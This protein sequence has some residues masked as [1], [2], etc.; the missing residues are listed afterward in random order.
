MVPAA[1]LKIGIPGGEV[2]KTALPLCR[3]TGSRIRN[4]ASCR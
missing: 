1:D 2:A 3:M 4:P